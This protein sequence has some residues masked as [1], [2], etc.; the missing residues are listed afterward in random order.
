[1]ETQ[2]SFNPSVSKVIIGLIFVISF[3]GS[4]FAQT[5]WHDPLKENYDVIQNGFTS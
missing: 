2:E 4:L 5:L 1:M 3:T